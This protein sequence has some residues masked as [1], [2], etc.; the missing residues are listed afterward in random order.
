M[1]HYEH[2]PIFKKMLELSVYIEGLVRHFSRYHKYTLGSELRALCHEG[3]GFIAEANSL[4]LHERR[5]ALL[6]LRMKLERIKIHLMLA[7]E[8]HA[9]NR[10][11]S[12]FHATSLVVEV[13]RQ[14]EGWLRS[15]SAGRK[16]RTP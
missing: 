9:F 1:A 7:K 13:S 11:R 5:P 3:L 14:N 15:V 4:P 12:F 2:L 6:R 8:V 16:R 10:T